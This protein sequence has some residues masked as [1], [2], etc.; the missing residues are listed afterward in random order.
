[1]PELLVAMVMLLVVVGA[2]LT[3]L[4]V[5]TRTQ[6]RDQSYAQEVST[7]Q[8]A[9]ARLV[10]DVRGA[11][12]V[13]PV[14]P[15]QLQF[16]E[17]VYVAGVPTTYNVEYNCTAPDTLGSPYT[18]CARTQAVAPALPP[19]YG[20][21]PGPQDIQHVWN[22]PSNLTSGNT[23]A[24]FCNSTGSATSGSVFFV[25][26]PNTANPDGSS[27]TCDE[28]YEEVWVAPHPTYLRVRLQVPASGDQKS[29]GLKHYTVLQD[30]TYLPNSD[31]G[32]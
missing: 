10:H 1:M 3:L 6:A 8:V 9:L 31:A 16:A 12:S 20:S 2:T 4:V 29:G 14:G 24:T 26:N 23:F 18:R 21:T 17:T 13:G 11:I 22:N 27:L 28:T 15:G 32:S 19:V 30:G 7:T 5:A 25:S